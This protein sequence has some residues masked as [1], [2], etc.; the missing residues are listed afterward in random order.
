VG[1]AAAEAEEG[2][3]AITSSHTP[4]R[5]VPGVWTLPTR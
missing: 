1:T 3:R 4:E 2:V 5:S